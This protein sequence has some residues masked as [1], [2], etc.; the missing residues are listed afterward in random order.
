MDAT[1]GLWRKEYRGDDLLIVAGGGSILRGLNGSEQISPGKIIAY[2]HYGPMI[3]DVADANA[4]LLARAPAL[5]NALMRCRAQWIHSVNAPEC[6]AALN[7]IVDAQG[8]YT[9]QRNE[10][11]EALV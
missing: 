1:G 6:L 3:A 8:G 2:V 7:G 11:E 5:R 9:E 4:D 10:T